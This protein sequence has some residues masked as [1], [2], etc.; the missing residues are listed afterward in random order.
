[1][2]FIMKQ[3]RTVGKYKLNSK[4]TWIYKQKI[5]FPQIK[6]RIIEKAVA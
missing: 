3:D 1:M 5:R 4:S 6:P 2:F